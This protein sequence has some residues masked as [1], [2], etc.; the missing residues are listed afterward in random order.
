MRRSL[1][2]SP[3]ALVFVVLAAIPAAAGGWA[4]GGLDSMPAGVV[5]GKP[6]T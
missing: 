4:T 2:V 5:P 6:G 3:L 1:L